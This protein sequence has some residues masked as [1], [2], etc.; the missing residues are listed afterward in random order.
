MISGIFPGDKRR[1]PRPEMVIKHC[2]CQSC[3]PSGRILRSP[4][5]RRGVQGEALVFQDGFVPHGRYTLRG[6]VPGRVHE[7]GNIVG[8]HLVLGVGTE[9]AAQGRDVVYPG[10][11]PEVFGL[12]R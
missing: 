8:L 11:Q 4:P 2:V 6:V 7:G 10:V 1:F 9:Q 3:S 5:V 12:L